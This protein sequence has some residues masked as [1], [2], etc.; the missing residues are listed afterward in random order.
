MPCLP[1]RTLARAA[2]SSAI[3]CALSSNSIRRCSVTCSQSVNANGLCWLLSEDQNGKIGAIRVLNDRNCGKARLWHACLASCSHGVVLVARALEFIHCAMV[4]PL[5]CT[6]VLPQLLTN[7]EDSVLWH[8][9][10]AY[11]H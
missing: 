6:L 10:V 8:L 1:Q 5:F 11:S 9:R 2:C 3:F 7:S 4:T